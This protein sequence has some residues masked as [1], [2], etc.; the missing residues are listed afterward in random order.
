[1]WIEICWK[2]R[3]LDVIVSSTAMIHLT[4]SFP[5]RNTTSL[6]FFILGR[7]ARAGHPVSAG[8]NGGSSKALVSMWKP[9]GRTRRGATDI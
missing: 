4:R 6:S 8:A 5:H 9:E 3:C 7:S 1:M 2:P